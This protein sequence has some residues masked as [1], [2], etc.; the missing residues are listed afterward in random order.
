MAI[1]SSDIVL[2]ATHVATQQLN[3]TESARVTLNN[4]R[5]NSNTNTNTNTPPFPALEIA[6]RDT[7]QASVVQIS[8]AAKIAQS[9][10]SQGE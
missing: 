2:T 1:T 8:D 10:D 6:G 5:T 4:Q 7:R 9:Q 3:V